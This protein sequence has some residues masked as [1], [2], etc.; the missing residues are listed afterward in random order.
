MPEEQH[1]GTPNR[2]VERIIAEHIHKQIKNTSKGIFAEDTIEKS[3]SVPDTFRPT[4]D[5][6][7]TSFRNSKDGMLRDSWKE[8]L[9]HLYMNLIER[10]GEY[11]NITKDDK[12]KII[13]NFVET[14]LLPGSD[15][16]MV[17]ELAEK[18]IKRFEIIFLNIGKSQLESVNF[19]NN[20]DMMYGPKYRPVMP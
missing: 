5:H 16:P 8:H 12:E 10:S 1:K 4:F 20:A 11:G 9:V 15:E 2:E 17:Y 6:F 18:T 13:G 3:N 19:G 14:F 7:V